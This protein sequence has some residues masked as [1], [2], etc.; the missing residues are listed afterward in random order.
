MRILIFSWRDIKYPGWGGAEVLTLKLAKCWVAKGHK[1]S[2]ISAKFPGAKGKEIIEGVRIFRPAKFYAQSPF[3]YLT[4]LYQTVKFYR[5]QLAG[6]YDLVIDQVHGVPFFTPF[7]VKEKVIFFPLE[8][9]KTIWFYEVQFPFS[10]I[11]FL[12]ELFY[13]RVF[14][15]R[16]FL[17]IS[18]STAEDLTKFGAKDVYTITPGANFKPFKKIPQKNRFPVL[19]SLGRITEMKRIEHIIQAF[20]LLHKELPNIKL[21][22]AGQGEAKYLTKLKELCR[23]TAIDD[24]VIFTGFLSESEKRRYLSQAWILVSSSLRE[25]WGLTV[26]EAAACGTP[27]VAYRIPGLVD[28]IKNQE[29]GFLCQKNNPEELAKNIKR[30][31]V[32]RSLRKRISQNALNHSRNLTW[33]K[34]AAEGLLVFEKII[35][36]SPLGKS[37]KA[38]RWSFLSKIYP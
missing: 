7:F 21:I 34:T 10:L 29:T 20:R 12:L 18:P 32:N 8:V 38:S 25:G 11:G 22:V 2:I 37:S 33:E 26:I 14:R 13:I 9:A 24:R 30:L 3:E 4:F 27:T 17:T 5:R 31:L 23:K 36:Q 28:S 6:K 35:S 15:N 1:V 16:P 19:I